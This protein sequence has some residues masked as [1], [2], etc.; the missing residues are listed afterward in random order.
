MQ[1]SNYNVFHQAENRGYIFNTRRET[2]TSVSIPLLEAVRRKEVDRIPESV[3]TLL[4]KQGVIATNLNEESRLVRQ[5][6]LGKR[7]H[8][9][10]RLIVVPTYSCN[11]K[12]SYCYVQNVVGQSTP[13]IASWET[14]IES[15]IQSRLEPKKE[16]RLTLAFFGGEPLL[17]ADR[18]LKLVKKAKVLMQQFNGGFYSTLTT[19]G[20]IVNSTVENLLEHIDFCQVTLDGTRGLH[21]KYRQSQTGKGTYSKIIG[22]LN[23]ATRQRCKTVVRYHL[24]NSQRD[25]LF[26]QALELKE[27][28]DFPEK[29]A[30]YFSKVAAGCY[31]EIMACDY[32]QNLSTEGLAP[33]LLARKAFA[34]AGWAEE[35]LYL[36]NKGNATVSCSSRCG[37]LGTESFL[38]DAQN[39]IFFCPVALENTDLQIGKLEKGGSRFFPIRNQL[40]S[41]RRCTTEECD[42]CALLPLCEN[43]C[44]TKA[45]V[46]NDQ[47]SSTF[48]DKQ[49]LLLKIKQ[50][51]ENT[52][53]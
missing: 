17:K 31:K 39:R 22:F 35:L 24:H 45:L 14:C 52:P 43:G 40:L 2:V 29:V 12:C 16:K 13:S 18:C 28:L 4:Q 20:S 47:A 32:Q 53:S 34:K 49:R 3:K 11:L 42:R 10:V 5:E 38:I 51:C 26:K 46:N 37:Y 48:C 8:H 27:D 9:D 21:D 41:Q 25:E 50:R 19:N 1:L 33:H 36:H 30:I 23:R 7:I 6:S 44:P 15:F